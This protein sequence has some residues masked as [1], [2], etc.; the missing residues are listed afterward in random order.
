MNPTITFTLDEDFPLRMADRYGRLREDARYE[1]PVWGDVEISYLADDDWWVH[2]ITLSASN[3]KMGAACEGWEQE[4]DAS[5]PLYKPIERYLK[6]LRFDDVCAAIREHI[7]DQR[8][9]Y[10][11]D[12]GKERAKMRGAA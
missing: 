4:I 3:G 8:D 10:L 1:I 12:L 11:F 7:K 5:H 2:G 6:E 9:S